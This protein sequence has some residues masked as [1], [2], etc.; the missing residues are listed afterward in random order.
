MMAWP[1]A[2]WRSQWEASVFGM[3]GDRAD[4]LMGSVSERPS[5]QPCG[6]TDHGPSPRE[7]VPF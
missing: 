7:V 2:V 6:D 4:R 3:F 5:S 1:E